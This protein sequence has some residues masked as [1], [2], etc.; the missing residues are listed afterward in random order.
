M[1][2]K[3]NKPFL[4]YTYKERTTVIEDSFDRNSYTGFHRSETLASVTG[5]FFNKPKDNH[6]NK[7]V[8][9]KDSDDDDLV[10]KKL[11]LVCVKYST[12]GTFNCESGQLAVEG[13]YTSRENA[14]K[15]I[16]LIDNDKYDEY[17]P[18]DGYFESVED[19]YIKEVLVKR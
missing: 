13:A 9:V 10:N 18:W 12:G 11:F 2:N 7:V 3:K 14:E 16:D 1:S 8:E 15:V 6:Y 19:T 17:C 4:Y 5:V